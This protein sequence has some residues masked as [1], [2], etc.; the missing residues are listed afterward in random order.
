MI[1]C[2]LSNP[3]AWLQTSQD[4]YFEGPLHVFFFF[5]CVCCFIFDWILGFIFEAGSHYVDLTA[6]NSQRSSC[7]GLEVCTTKAS[8]PMPDVFLN[9]CYNSKGSITHIHTCV[10]AQGRTN[11][12]KNLRKTLQ[13]F[14]N[15]SHLFV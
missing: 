13:L 10:H 9:S 8:I 11:C 2:Y 1:V 5:L 4:S 12:A 3:V 6:L 14:P 7:L 15:I